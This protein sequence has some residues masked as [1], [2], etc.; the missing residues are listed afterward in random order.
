MAFIDSSVVNVALP[1]MELDLATTLPAMTWVINAYT[2]CMSAL[3]LIGGA[4]ADQIGRRRIFLTGL[5]IFAAASVAC[6]LAPRVEVLTL[7][8]AVQGVGAALLIPCSL[9]IIGAAFD[10]KERGA[11][12]GVWSGASA[13]AAGAAPMMGGWL[14][15]HGS[16][17]AIFLINPVIAVPTILIALR[18]LPESIDPDAKKGLDARGAALA[19]F[20]LG[21]LVYGLITASEQSWRSPVVIG[22]LALGAVLLISFVLAERRSPIPMMP[23]NVFQSLTFSGVNILT[24]LLYGALGGAMF[25]LPFLLIQVHGYSATEAGAAF[26]PFT[27]VLALLSRWG[28]R[29]VDRYGA[30]RPLIVGPLVVAVGFFLLSVPG[31]AGAYWTTFFLPMVILGFGMAITVSPLTTT[32]L[33]SVAPHQ[34]GVA[35]GINNAVAQVASLLTIAILGTFGLAALSHSLDQHMARTHDASAAVHKIVADARKG[36]VMPGM[37][38][39]TS[40][41][42]RQTAHEIVAD[43]F[44]DTIRRVVLIAASLALASAASAALTIKNTAVSK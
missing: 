24:L 32:V 29:L 17:R 27:I 15:D 5:S 14:V 1:K 35:S 21:L 42:D 7:A 43:S 18:H 26:L 30:R 4:A 20:G 40:G 44:R 11:A 25:F 13:I 31:T 9:A 10:E 39:D 36:F 23:L 12:I 37:P 22:S 8:R 6:G 34:T 3:L 16:W 19:F 41:P 28:G 2:L 38:P 33:N